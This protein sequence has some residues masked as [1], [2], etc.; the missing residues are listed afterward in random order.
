MKYTNI[1]TVHILLHVCQ[2]SMVPIGLYKLWQQYL[3][4][5]LKPRA[6]IEVDYFMCCAYTLVSSFRWSPCDI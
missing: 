2:D 4:Q 6:Q 5:K 1:Y 3:D